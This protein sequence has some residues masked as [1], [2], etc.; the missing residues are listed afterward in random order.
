MISF[1]ILIKII[2]DKMMSEGPAPE[3][4]YSYLL[5]LLCVVHTRPTTSGGGRP[6]HFGVREMRS[7]GARR[8]V[9]EHVVRLHAVRCVRPGT[10]DA[11][12]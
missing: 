5:A 4:L 9:H 3:L 12:G 7:A 11:T 10:R 2:M 8:A 1:Q 6:A